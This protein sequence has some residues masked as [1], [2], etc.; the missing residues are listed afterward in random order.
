[1][2]DVFHE[3]LDDFM[4]CYINDIFIFLKNMEDHECHVHMVLEKLQ[5]VRFYTKLEKCDSINLKRNFWVTS[6]LEMVFTWIFIKFGSLLIRLLQLLFK[7]FN[8]YLD[9]LIFINVS[10]PI[11]FQ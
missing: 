11:I 7:M 9:L 6:S 10:L 8:V 5:K 3:Y 4:V 2:N 1:M